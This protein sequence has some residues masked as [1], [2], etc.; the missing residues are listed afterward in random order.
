MEGKLLV[1]SAM[2]VR[3][4]GRAQKKSGRSSSRLRG[5]VVFVV[6]DSN[7]K[8]L[9]L[10]DIPSLWRRTRSSNIRFEV[11]STVTMTDAV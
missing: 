10:T 4:K 2:S 1:G 5:G 11:F 8:N 7:Q 3:S 6:N 9:L